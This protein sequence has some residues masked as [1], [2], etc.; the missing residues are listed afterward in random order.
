MS[1][2]KTLF[3]YIFSPQILAAFVLVFMVL[4]V[5]FVGPLLG[6]GT[7]HP[8]G[9]VGM[10]VTVIVILL[11]VS[12]LWLLKLPVGIIGI[13]V[14]CLLLWHAGPL[15]AVGNTQPLALAGIRI[16]IILSIVLCYGSY[17]LYRLVQAMRSD[18]KLLHKIFHPKQG[19]ATVI[20][21]DEIRTVSSVVEKAVQQLRKMRSSAGIW[22][23]FQSKRYLYEL[24]WYMII[25]TPEAGKTT[26]IRNAGLQFPL[27]EQMGAALTGNSDTHN[28]YWWFTN[29]AVL[30]DTAGRYTEQTEQVKNKKN[31]KSSDVNAAEWFGFLGQLRRFRPLAPINGA[32]LTI[33]VVDLLKNTPTD[34]I[35]I[36]AAMRARLTELRS[37][38]GIRFPVYVVVTKLDLLPGFIEYFQSLTDEQRA[39]I[40]G[41]TL[42][43]H[44]ENA[45]IESDK[46]RA[47]CEQEL[48]LLE[49]RLEAGIN[50]RLQKEYDIARRKKLYALPQE[51]R[52]LVSLLPEMLEQIFFDSRYDNTQLQ[53]ALRGVYF[54][55]A[56]QSEERL[57]AD[58]S[59]L[60]Q[61]FQCGVMSNQGE[62]ELDLGR[63][64]VMTNRR[65]F[66]LHN[67]FQHLIFTEAHL[68]RPNLRWELRFRVMR[69]VGHLLTITIFLWIGSAL[70]TSFGNNYQYLQVIKDKTDALEKQVM[71]YRKA[72]NVV[73]ISEVLNAARDVAQYKEINLNNPDSEYRYGLYS[74]PVLVGAS[75]DTYANL[76][77][78]LLLPQ[79]VR[80]IDAALAT[81]I[82]I[83]DADAVFNTLAVYLMLFSVDHFDGQTVRSWVLRDWERSD[84]AAPLG[85]QA[86]MARHLDALFSDGQKMHPFHPKNE[87]LI[88]SARAFLDSNP[89]INRLYERAKAKMEKEAPDNFTLLRVIG[90]QTN[91]VLAMKRDSVLVDGIPG[92]FTFEGYHDVFNKRLPELVG[93]ALIEDTWVMGRRDIVGRTSSTYGRGSP[94]LNLNIINDI[95]RLYLIDYG[96]FWHTFLDDIRPISSSEDIASG[97]LALDVQTLRVLAAPDSPLARLARA[98]VRE[99]SLSATTLPGKGFLTDIA[100]NAVGKTSRTANAVGNLH[101]PGVELTLEKQLVDNRFAAL[102]EV[103]TGQADTGSGPALMMEERVQ[104]SLQLDAITGLLNEQYT[105]LVIADN[106]LSTNNMPPVT[107][108]GVKLRM[109]SARLPEPFRAVLSGIAENAAEKVRQDVERLEIMQIKQTIA[110]L[111]TQIETSIGYACRT[112]IEGKYP[113]VASNQEVNIEDFTRIFSSGGL[114]DDFFQKNLAAHVDS[115]IQPWRYKVINANLPEL[116]RPDLSPFQR[117]AA[118]REVF[119]RDPGAKRMSWKLD[120]KVASIDPDIMQLVIDVDGQTSRY[121]HGPVMPFSF[122]WPGPRGGAIAEI[123]AN[124]RIRPDTS[125]I[126]TNGP[127]ALFRLLERGRIIETASSDRLAVEYTFDGRQAVLDLQ[128]GSLPN[129]LSGQLLKDFH[130]PTGVI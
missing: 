30:I 44:D 38:L 99:T 120:V 66:F 92:L 64:P 129:P 56:I 40:W 78:Q 75:A 127:W 82:K 33:S 36:V 107:D 7:F 58:H 3:N 116:R 55:S 106:A 65:N 59:T 34:R 104:R 122:S 96:N 19:R 45:A 77:Q 29:D 109:E 32:L 93:Q 130:C 68:V 22:G 54:T 91:V 42:P 123:T 69:I 67:L 119:F 53:A 81:S 21:G 121:S 101:N 63:N 9:T 26:A 76:L 46:L 23:L 8:F 98:A 1:Y 49:Q 83:R 62:S 31:K 110:L 73:N 114:I 24:P 128:T 6:F 39:Q 25:G 60:I 87:N 43:Y 12:L 61:R 48:Q 111:S 74:A 97:S 95:R 84:S 79:I 102:R 41:F 108:V 86:A 90:P 20:A 11:A 88:N 16:L 14:L 35:A 117:A 94:A 80:R 105:L 4:V 112:A 18:D 85:G 13:A 27:A 70:V 51:F 17:W 71:T 52:S 115:S 103:V 47:N 37:H 126:L 28:C 118:I 10:R 15:V 113:F 124:P 2:L 50:V 5:W 89:N 72:P 57:E 100:L 125:T